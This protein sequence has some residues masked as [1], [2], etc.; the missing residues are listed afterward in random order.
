MKQTFFL[1]LATLGPI[2]YLPA[3]GT[4]GTLATIPLVFLVQQMLGTG[5]A[6][7]LFTLIFTLVS[8][9]IISRA[10]KVL[11]N[12]AHNYDNDPQQIILD[13]VVGCLVLFA[14]LPLSLNSFS[15]GVLL[16]RALDIFK[17]GFIGQM[18]KLPGAWGNVADDV[19]AGIVSNLIVH[20]LFFM[21]AAC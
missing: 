16:F 9:F 10:L 15:L 5:T 4:W 2:G 20:I 6:Y 8:L 14:W 7:V 12:R 11:N 21:I 3:P 18:E 1:H 17:P 19:L 13:E